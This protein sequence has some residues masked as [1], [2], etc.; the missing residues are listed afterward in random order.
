MMFGADD[1]PRAEKA[2]AG[3][4]SL[5]DPAGFGRDFRGVAGR[6]GEHHDHG[7]SKAHQAKRVQADRLAVKIAIK[8]DQA[9]RQRG[10]AKTQHNFPPVRQCVTSR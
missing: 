8:T 2:D 5:N 3:E 1:D 10:D 6:V 4:D 7:R 9:A